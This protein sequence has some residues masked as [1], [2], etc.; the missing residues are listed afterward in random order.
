VFDLT[1]VP[2]LILLLFTPGNE[3]TLANSGKKQTSKTNRDDR[4]CARV[5]LR[6]WIEM[7]VTELQLAI[8]RRIRVEIEKLLSAKMIASHNHISAA[9]GTCGN[10]EIETR[11]RLLASILNI[12]V[13]NSATSD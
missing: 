9:S 10:R 7:E 13:S 5:I 6:N 11:S 8:F 1:L 3:I 2:H 12:L 4:R